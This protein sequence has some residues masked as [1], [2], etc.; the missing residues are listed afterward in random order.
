MND[1]SIPPIG[2]GTFPLRGE[3]M[4]LA[5]ASALSC[6]YRLFDTA[7]GYENDDSLGIALSEALPAIGMTRKD[8]FLTSKIGDKLLNGAPTGSFFYD[9]PSCLNRNVE[10][11]VKMQMESTLNHLK[12]DY[13]DILLIHYPYPTHKRI[14]KVFEKFYQEGMVKVIGVSN[15]RKRHL[16][17]LMED[18]SISPM[19]N[20]YE[21]HPLNTKKEVLEY[22]KLNHIVVEASSPLLL[23][24]QPIT[25]SPVLKSLSLKYGKSISQIILRWNIQLGIIPIPKSGNPKRIKENLSVFDFALTD[26]E[27]KSIDGM[28][29]NYINL[30]ESLYCP[31]Y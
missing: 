27:I 20:Q 2:L 16:M 14:W 30:P 29:E 22:C 31:G 15:Y 7:Y 18:C 4:N 9:S 6:G 23:M 8:I 5:V 11:V 26:D 17:D 25:E 3:Q 13:V 12:T 21:H 10:D 24:Q 1:F 28:N 19:V